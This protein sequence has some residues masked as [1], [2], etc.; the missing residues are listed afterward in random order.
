M[1]LYVRSL[2]IAE[3]RRLQSILRQGKVRRTI[4]RAQVIL[5]SAQSYRVI[6][7]AE[8]TYMNP[9]YVRNLIRRFNDEGMDLIKE[10]PRSGRPVIFDEERKA[11]IIEIAMSPP[12]LLGQPFSRWSLEKLRVYLMKTRVVRSISIETLRTIL[13]EYKVRL[14]RTKT[15]KESNDP[16][17]ESKKN[18]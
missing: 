14:Q 3:G 18:D 15:W 13:R 8:A 2:R 1:A 6:E 17:F 9:E 12:G 16:A 11:E 5:M 10:K 7:I 4:R